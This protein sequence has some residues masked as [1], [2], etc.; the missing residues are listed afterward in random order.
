MAAI[1]Y[2]P[3]IKA[4]GT[5]DSVEL[6]RWFETIRLYVSLTDVTLGDLAVATDYYMEVAKGNISGSTVVHKF[7][8]AP[9]IDSA[10]GFVDIWDG[11]WIDNALKTYTFSTTADIDRVSSSNTTDTFDVEVQGL[12]TNYDL[13]V[14]TI[15]LTGQ[16]PVALTT[17]LIRVFR[18][19]NVSA[20]AASGTIFCFVNVATTAGVP[21]TITNTR[22][23]LTIG[24]EQTM[25][26][27]YTIPAGKTG[28]MTG[29]TAAINCKLS[30]RCVVQMLMRAFGGIFQVKGS[31]SVDSEGTSMMEVKMT[32][33][34][35]IPEKT[36]ILIR[37]DSSVNNASL[38]A[39]FEI[40]LVDD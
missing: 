32:V 33:P 37:G 2:P 12:D 19:K 15:T 1:P 34:A 22:A 5:F 14:Q 35:K 39:T 31:G 9:D 28:Y 4:D 24:F 36:D 21:D 29:R 23:V 10:D 6:L 38:S 16:T 7:G 13:T 8:A 3:R 27:I 11:G 26:A 20:T 40:I 30:G 25:M 17:S 18:M